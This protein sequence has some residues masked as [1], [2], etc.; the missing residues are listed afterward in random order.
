MHSA[1]MAPGR[2]L[3]AAFII[4]FECVRGVPKGPVREVGP[5][6]S[7]HGTRITFMPDSEIFQ[8]IGIQTRDPPQTGARTGVPECRCPYHIPG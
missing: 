5:A 6:G 3:A 7:K 2:R 1:N 4:Q 8:D